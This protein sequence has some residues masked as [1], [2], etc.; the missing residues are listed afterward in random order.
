MASQTK[1]HSIANSIARSATLS[2]LLWQAWRDRDYLESRPLVTVARAA[3]A[4]YSQSAL[5]VAS[6]GIIRTGGRGRQGRQLPPC[7]PP[8][9][10]G[11]V[12]VAPVIV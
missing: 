1:V 10:Y 9:R 8:A 11:P 6:V 12:G 3:V 4:N 7:P 2:H 5:F